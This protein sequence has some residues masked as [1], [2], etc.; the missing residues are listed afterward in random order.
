MLPL[1]PRLQP[2][3]KFATNKISD[4]EA[5]GMAERAYATLQKAAGKGAEE[6]KTVDA[7]AVVSILK[8]ALGADANDVITAHVAGLAAAATNLRN[9]DA[10]VWR[11]DVGYPPFDSVIDAVR[12]KLEVSLAPEEELEDEDLDGVDM[13]KKVL[14]RWHTV[15]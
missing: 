6:V 2:L 15:P 13:Y 4:P 11:E 9:F 1:M 8:E 7:A 5:R 12:A 3:V 10:G 14:S